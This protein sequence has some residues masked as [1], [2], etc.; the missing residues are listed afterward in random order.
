MA[1]LSPIT[2]FE[3]SLKTMQTDINHLT[4]TACAEA[5]RGLRCP[6]NYSSYWRVI[7][8]TVQPPEHSWIHYPQPFNTLYLICKT[9]IPMYIQGVHGA[10]PRD[11]SYVSSV[12]VLDGGDPVNSKAAISLRLMGK[13]LSHRCRWT[14]GILR[15]RPANLYT[16]GRFLKGPLN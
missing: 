14:G 10:S 8:S 13:L 16:F 5:R 3:P 7:Y 1:I 11:Q 6:C 4:L 12:S 2:F 15:F 9:L